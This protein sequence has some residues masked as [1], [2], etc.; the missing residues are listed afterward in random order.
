MSIIGDK[1]KEIL[2]LQELNL[3]VMKI[4]R[5]VLLTL[6]MG[7]FAVNFLTV[8]YQNLWSA[9]NLWSYIR[10]GV[11]LILVLLLLAMVRRDMKKQ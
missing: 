10:I 8:D 9:A 7:L 11:A 6:A 4:F 2:S 3:V 5:I 1:S